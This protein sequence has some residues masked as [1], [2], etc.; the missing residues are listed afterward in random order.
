MF[1]L[2]RIPLQEKVDFAKSL[3]VMLKS[4]MAID[5]ALS[6][7]AEQVSSR[8]FRS[9]IHR[10]KSE[11]E[12]GTSLSAAFAKEERVFGNVFVSFLKAGE[13]SGTLEGNLSFFADWLERNN[14]LKKEISAVLLYPKIVFG[15]TFLVAGGLAV[16]IL[17]RLIPLF[18]TL[19][20]D[21]PLTTRVLLKLSLFL[22][23]F[24]FLVVLGI[25]GVPIAFTLLNKVKAAK[26]LFHFLYISAPFFGTLAAQYQLA[27]I[28]Q[29]FSTLFRS[30]LPISESLRITGQAATNM[31]YQESLKRIRERVDKGTTLS[32]ALAGYPRLYPKNFVTIVAVGEKS[33]T[34]DNSAAYLSEFY[35]KE[36]RNKTK[37]LPTIVEPLL[38]LLVGVI[39]GFVA[40]SIIMPIYE[41][42]SG[43]SR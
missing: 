31:H 5:E 41:L 3:A 37:K 6:S 33:G 42:T 25:I 7:L 34:L 2:N 38:L 11:I 20:I 18:E 4:G 12:M 29:L 1:Y 14:D 10:V 28:A 22:Q 17:P 27:L 35:S 40:F 23:N 13:A 8:A 19:R 32:Q 9:I 39:V 26:R 36:V 15:A 16:F 21:L 43:L 24:W 30:G